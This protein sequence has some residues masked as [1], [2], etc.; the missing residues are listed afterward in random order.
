MISPI[1]KPEPRKR[2]PYKRTA[3][4]QEKRLAAKL[5]GRR[6]PLSG[7]GGIAGDVLAAYVIAECKT[8][9]RLDTQGEKVMTLHKSWL[10]KIEAEAR[11][12]GKP[13]AITEIRFKGDRTSWTLMN[14]DALVA[15][16]NENAA[17]RE[18]EKNV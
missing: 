1:P 17:Y 6:V 2:N 13:F 12:E 11:M 8:S 15:L 4:K 10:T 16:L 5:D 14:T 18:Q 3:L 9:H 7:G